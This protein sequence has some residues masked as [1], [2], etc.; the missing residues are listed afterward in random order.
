MKNLS[1]IRRRLTFHFLLV[2]KPGFKNRQFFSRPAPFP[3]I[4]RFESLCSLNF[5]PRLPR[6][7]I[8]SL[9]TT[10]YLVSL[11]HFSLL[12][13]LLG[14][15][16]FGLEVDQLEKAFEQKCSFWSELRIS[17]TL[18]KKIWAVANNGC[19]CKVLNWSMAFLTPYGC[20]NWNRQALI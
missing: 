5:M 14:K 20:S 15:Q 2:V 17:M 16:I 18:R 11:L 4:A 19:C 3:G 12:G 10:F 1:K 7:L 6:W 13:D 9:L 8:N